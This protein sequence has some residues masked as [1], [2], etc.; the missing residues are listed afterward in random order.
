VAAPNADDLT[1]VPLLADLPEGDRAALAAS[2]EVEEHPAGEHVV[3]QG[4]SGYAFYVL[5]DGRAMVEQGGRPLRE[6]GPGEHFGEFAIL[7][8]GRR[9]ATVTAL[10][11]VVVWALFGTVFRSLETSRPDLADAL[12]QAM[13]ERLGDG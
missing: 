5:A 7:G 3:T 11:P 4:R 6:I 8:D 10:T 13:A 9:T 1:H 2:F 12:R